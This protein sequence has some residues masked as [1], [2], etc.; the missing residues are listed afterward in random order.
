VLFRS[1]GSSLRFSL[2][3]L[4]LKPL[5]ER[6]SSQASPGKMK[7]GPQISDL[8]AEAERSVQ[9]WWKELAG[10]GT[11]SSVVRRQASGV[12]VEENRGGAA[13]VEKEIGEAST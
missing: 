2:Q 4:G 7:G 8:R 3:T 12:R 5:G 11:A 10:C 1:S 13:P 6:S 9:Y